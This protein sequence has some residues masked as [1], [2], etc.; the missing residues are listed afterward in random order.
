MTGIRALG[1]GGGEISIPQCSKEETNEEADGLI[2]EL[3]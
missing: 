1:C 3:P 2:E